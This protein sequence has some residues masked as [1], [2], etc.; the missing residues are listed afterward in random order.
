MNLHDYSIPAIRAHVEARGY[1]LV[2][3]KDF[4]LT[5]PREF[6]LS[7]GYSK[8]WLTVMR[9][10]GRITIPRDDCDFSRDGRL[11]RF[12]S[13]PALEEFCKK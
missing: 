11:I 4:P 9:K 1:L 8:D 6:S 2:A 13:N 12:R 5:T 3:K 7:H 10:R